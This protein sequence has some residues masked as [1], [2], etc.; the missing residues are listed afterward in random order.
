MLYWQAKTISSYFSRFEKWAKNH[1]DF[2]RFAAEQH[3]K[4]IPV[5]PYIVKYKTDMT[6]S[7]HSTGS[8]KKVLDPSIGSPFRTVVVIAVV[9]TKTYNKGEV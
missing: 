1:I 7:F 4:T 5:N 2:V 9:E 6:E 8:I 3:L